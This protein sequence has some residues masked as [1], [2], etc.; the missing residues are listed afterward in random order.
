VI[1]VPK[2]LLEIDSIGLLDGQPSA[3]LFTPPVDG[4]Y[5]VSG[6]ADTL[7]PEGLGAVNLQLTWT[8][9]FGLMKRDI[10]IDRLSV[11]RSTV[12]HGVP[13]QPV[14]YSLQSFG[15]VQLYNLHIVVEQLSDGQ[16]GD[17]L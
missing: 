16:P 7:N 6:Y 10:E 13:S 1:K 9:P 11:I 3:S 8:D 4:L 5:R 17:Q 12:F 2:I 15:S 14:S